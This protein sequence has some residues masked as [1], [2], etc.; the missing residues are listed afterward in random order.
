MITRHLR[1]SLGRDFQLVFSSKSRGAGEV[2]SI[3][4]VSLNSFM[5][6]GWSGCPSGPGEKR[7][8]VGY[9]FRGNNF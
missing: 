8:A 1:R 5:R 2:K 9:N 3:P 7:L 6:F 4:I